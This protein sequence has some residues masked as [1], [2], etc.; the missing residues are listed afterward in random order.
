M[1]PWEFPEYSLFSLRKSQ[2]AQGNP[3]VSAKNPVNRELVRIVIKEEKPG[4]PWFFRA[5]SR[6][7]SNRKAVFPR[8]LRAVTIKV[9]GALKVPPQFPFIFRVN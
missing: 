2:K 4:I 5:M 1:F 8:E 3:L 6:K 7:K 9:K